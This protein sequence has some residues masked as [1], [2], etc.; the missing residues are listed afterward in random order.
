MPPSTAGKYQRE[1]SKTVQALEGRWV[2]S[3]TMTWPGKAPVQLSNVVLDCKKV[4]GGGAISCSHGYNVPDE[5]R[6]E[7][8][9]LIGVDSHTGVVHRYSVNSKGELRDHQG[10]WT[11]DRTL[12]LDAPSFAQGKPATSRMTLTFPMPDQL[13]FRSVAYMPGGEQAT[14]EVSGKREIAR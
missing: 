4:A 14:F 13:N 10:V 7:E 11:D 6:Q 3:G 2:T 5:G 12:M 9:A 8:A 1:Q